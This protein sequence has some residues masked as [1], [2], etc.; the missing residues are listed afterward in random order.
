MFCIS[1]LHIKA[2]KP[3]LISIKNESL[4][5]ELKEALSGSDCMPE[6]IPGDEGVVE[7]VCHPD[8]VTVVIGIDGYAALKK[9][10]LH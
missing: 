5:A 4:V 1:H 7:V 9:K 2:F 6:I 10:T 8:C 3:Q